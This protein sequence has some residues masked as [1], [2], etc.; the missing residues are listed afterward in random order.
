MRKLVA[1]TAVLGTLGVAGAAHGA[2]E[3]GTLECKIDPGIGLI[4]G[5][6]KGMECRYSSA[7]GQIVELY[8]GRV[9]KLG[10]DIGVTGESVVIW[11]VVAP[12][13]SLRPGALEGTYTGVGAEATVGVGPKANLLVGGSDKTISLQPVSVG[14]QA[15]LNV[16]A[17]ISSIALV[18]MAR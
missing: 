18:S 3:V 12:T 6:S 11:Q 2:A 1:V 9:S 8:E 15:G 17:G 4:I 14:A 7:D 5:S 10:L 13:T 16:A